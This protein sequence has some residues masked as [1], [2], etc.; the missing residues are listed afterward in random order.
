MTRMRVETSNEAK[1]LACELTSRRRSPEEISK[2]LDYFRANLAQETDET[3]RAVWQSQIDGLEK[4]RASEEY[5]AGDYAEGIDTLMLELVEWRALIFAFEGVDTKKAPFNRYPFFSQW[6]VGAVYAIFSLLGKLSSK[7]KRDNSLR[8]LWTTIAG[9]IEGDGA[10][11][12]EEIAEINRRLDP[13]NGQFTN[14][15]SKAMR[16]RNTVV[17]H[18]EKSF[19]M[20]WDE[21]DV[22][23]QT[24]VRIWSLIVSWS[25]FGVLNPFR[26]GEEAFAGLDTIFEHAELVL[27]RAKR[28]EYLDRVKVWCTTHLHT[29]MTDPGRGPFATISV[30]W[31]IP[32]A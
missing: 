16:F 21:L 1:A 7:D 10:C 18:N 2:S 3:S 5:Q 22:D 32:G 25:S 9:F 31:R 29:G 8:R 13:S 26:S 4:W 27:L 30:T 15:R 28:K 6:R 17:S 11:T 20:T 24:L 14:S 23:I 12:A 19:E